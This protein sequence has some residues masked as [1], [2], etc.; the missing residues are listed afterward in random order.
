MHWTEKS[1]RDLSNNRKRKKNEPR[2]LSVNA[3]SCIA[4]VKFMLKSKNS[5]STFQYS[6]DFR[7]M[8]PQ[9]LRF[10]EEMQNPFDEC[11]GLSEENDRSD[12]AI[13]QNSAGWQCRIMHNQRRKKMYIFCPVCE[14]KKVFLR[15]SQW[16]CHRKRS[17]MSYILA[18][19]DLSEA[20]NF[21]WTLRSSYNK[22]PYRSDPELRVPELPSASGLCIVRQTIIWRCV[23][24][25]VSSRA[26][27]LF[28]DSEG[29][30]SVE[31]QALHYLYRHKLFVTLRKSRHLE[32]DSITLSLTIWTLN[33]E[34]I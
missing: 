7:T 6:R 19:I 30:L 11:G 10:A 12:V 4:A 2:S 14:N 25:R 1:R 29:R 22:L 3:G 21:I 17:K 5:K 20:S 13:G 18:A 33:L 16:K 23:G 26:I 31:W 15:N 8:A 34:L 28:D 9:C 32:G 24:E 27:F